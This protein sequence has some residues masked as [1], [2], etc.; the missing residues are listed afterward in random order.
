MQ[1]QV[2]PFDRPRLPNLSKNDPLAH[3]G[4][5]SFKR[6]WRA[7]HIT[8]LGVKGTDLSDYK[9]LILSPHQT[10]ST[11]RQTQANQIKRK[12]SLLKTKIK[13]IFPSNRKKILRERASTMLWTHGMF[14]P[15]YHH[16]FSFSFSCC[17]T[18]L[19]NI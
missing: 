11:S 7:T 6:L 9:T 2:S 16:F 19:G 4:V 10:D 1:P 12:K 14:D 13:L 8:C 17:Q 18:S 5:S 15:Q 3:A